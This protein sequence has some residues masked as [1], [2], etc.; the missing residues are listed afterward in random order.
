MKLVENQNSI[1]VTCKDLSNEGKGVVFYNGRTGF[2]DHLLI[3]EEAKII[4]TYQKK[5]IFFG[6]IQSLITK[7]SDRIK[8]LCPYFYECGGC[9][10][11]HM[12][13]E[14]QLLYKKN[15]V[16][17]CLYHIGHLDIDVDSTIG[18]EDPTHYRNKIQVPIKRVKKKIVSGFYKEKS[19]DIVPVE[20]C[21]IENKNAD[22]IL[23][24]IR[25]LMKKYHIEPY[26]EDL[27][28]GVLRHVLIRNSRKSKENMVVLVTNCDAFPGRNDFVKEL[29]K[30]EP[31]IS[32]VVQNINLRDTNV[33]LGEKER[34]LSGKGF[35]EDT[36]CG[37]KFKISPKSFFQVNPVQTEKLYQ[38]AISS[39][40]L[41]EN[42]LIL[43]AYCGIGTIG[44]IAA[45]K[46]KKVIGVEIVKE[47]VFDAIKN[48]KENS[49]SN[50]FFYCGDA[51]EFI[52]EKFEEGIHFD[53]VFMDPPRKGSDEKFLNILRKTHPKKIVY[54]SCDPATLARDLNF[55]S[56]DYQIKKVTPIDMFPNTAH[57]ETVVVLSYK[58]PDEHKK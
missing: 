41:S 2:V 53:V 50:A 10:L 7:N 47:A 49:I 14:A 33:I 38:L 11:M 46:V 26:N 51:G 37:I 22:Q 32:T 5:D 4:I 55:L 57:I 13:Y 8:P 15:K 39:A 18:M 16:K 43:D 31:S 29:K 19:H 21:S 58:N 36:L 12:N 48:A 42:D 9:Q 45:S 17:E 35:I 28:K 54:I 40:E 44:L 25:N 24:T 3:G 6:K 27:R 30:L 23:N 1:I 52:Q 20:H 34:V 56:P